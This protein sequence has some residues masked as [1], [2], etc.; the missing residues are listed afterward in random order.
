MI[1]FE[2]LIQHRLM[3]N[4]FVRNYHEYDTVYREQL[5][6]NTQLWQTMY[7]LSPKLFQQKNVQVF[8]Y[9][10]TDL[11]GF[12]EV[13]RMCSI[14]LCIRTQALYCWQRTS[15]YY[16]LT[17]LALQK[18]FTYCPHTTKHLKHLHLCNGDNNGTAI[19]C[20]LS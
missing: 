3:T 10:C 19:K 11:L 1:Y 12:E 9:S 2:L 15:A 4:T 14:I 7:I 5:C 13:S 20:L 17:A 18:S 6:K 16:K 8:L